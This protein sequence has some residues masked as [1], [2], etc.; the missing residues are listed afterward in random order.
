MEHGP[1]LLVVQKEFP[2]KDYQRVEE[3]FFAAFHQSHSTPRRPLQRK[4]RPLERGPRQG[5]RTGPLARDMGGSLADRAVE[6]DSHR[7]LLGA[8]HSL[9]EVDHNLRADFEGIDLPAN[10]HHSAVA[11]GKNSPL[12]SDSHAVGIHLEAV[13]THTVG[14]A[15]AVD[16]TLLVEEDRAYYEDHEQELQVHRKGSHCQKSE[17]QQRLLLT[18]HQKQKIHLATQV[19]LPGQGPGLFE[20]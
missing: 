6:W 9:A 19:F 1:E 2:Q 7:I 16:N 17:D 8:A 15:D 3:S 12:H 20:A 18:K 5:Q 14:E 4:D 10:I 11:E 13:H